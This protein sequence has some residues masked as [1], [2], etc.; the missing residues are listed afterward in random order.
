M[1]NVIFQDADLVSA[2]KQKQKIFRIFLL[3]TAVYVVLCAFSLAYFISLPFE[4]PLQAAPKWIVWVASCLYVIF[5]FPYMG[6]KFHRARRYY[7]LISYFSVGMKQV[8]NSI[9]LRYEEPELKDG[10]DFYVLTMSEWSNKKSEYMDRKIF[11]DKEKPLPEFQEGDMVRYLTQGNLMI[12]YE[13][14]GHDDEFAKKIAQ[15]SVRE[16]LFS[17]RGEQL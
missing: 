2:Y 7:K 17:N 3:V 4:H 16:R 11:C 13:V 1:M 8:N 9:F 6:I 15:G 10:V 12:E 14:V 5:C